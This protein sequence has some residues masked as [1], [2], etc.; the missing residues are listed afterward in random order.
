[1]I[2]NSFPV[3]TQI[4]KYKETESVRGYFCGWYQSHATQEKE[5]GIFL[6]LMNIAEIIALV[7]IT[8][9]QKITF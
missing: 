1:M 4:S 3:R 8:G 5:K 6:V 2:Q 9:L 7:H